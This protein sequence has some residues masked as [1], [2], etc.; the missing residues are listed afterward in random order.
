VAVGCEYVQTSGLERTTRDAVRLGVGPR[1]HDLV[2]L[3]MSS[4]S[5]LFWEQLT[6]D[7]DLGLVTR[8][9]VAMLGDGKCESV[10][11]Y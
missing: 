5:S 8:G 1:S 4:D 9:W 3:A 7:A 2:L 11:A 6:I 10:A